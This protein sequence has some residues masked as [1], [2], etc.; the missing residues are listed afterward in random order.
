VELVRLAGQSSLELDIDEATV[1]LRRLV[2]LAPEDGQAWQTLGQ[3]LSNAGDMAAAAEAFRE[4]VRLRPE[5][6]G[7]LIDLGHAVYASHRTDEAIELL[8]RATQLDPGNLFA[9]RSLVEIH[10][11]A[12]NLQA[13]ETAAQRLTQLRPDDVLAVLETAEL[14]LALGMFDAAIAAY[15]RLRSIDLMPGHESLAYHGMI[16][17]EVQRE[18]WR[19][20]LDLAIDAT[21]VDRDELTTQLLALIAAKLFGDGDRPSPSRPELDA[22]L[23]AEHIE[24]RR[25]HAEALTHQ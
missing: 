11:H 12:G 13:A 20:A 25:F 24:H 5:D 23:A 8:W 2:E 10:K 21:R 7:A 15:G 14:N 4:A 19:R 3:A 16:Q 22:A 1:Y 17:A 18:R 6:A 9:L